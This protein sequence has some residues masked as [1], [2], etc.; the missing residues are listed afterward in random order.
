[1]TMVSTDKNALLYPT[2]DPQEVLDKEKVIDALSWYHLC[3][4]G[5]RQICGSF[6]KI[7]RLR[8]PKNDDLFYYKVTAGVKS[9]CENRRWS[10]NTSMKKNVLYTRLLHGKEELCQTGKKK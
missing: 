3:Q 1:M 8:W 5:L 10:Y 2:E 7:S 6:C 9:E 4:E